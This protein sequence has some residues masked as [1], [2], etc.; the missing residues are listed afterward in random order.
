LS[1]SGRKSDALNERSIA[2]VGVKEVEGGVI[3]DVEQLGGIMLENPVTT[4][5]VTRQTG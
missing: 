2:L 3:L 4:N 1:I 5:P